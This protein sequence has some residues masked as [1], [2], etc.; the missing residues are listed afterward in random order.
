MKYFLL[1]FV[2]LFIVRCRNDDR[3]VLPVTLTRDSSITRQNAYSDLFLDSLKM[4][5]FLKA[6][7]N[8]DS[9]KTYIRSFYN[10]RNFSFAWFNEEGLTIQTEGF[11]NLFNQY[12]NNSGDSNLYYSHLNNT[13]DGLLYQDT[14]NEVNADSLATI[15]LRLTKCFFYYVKRVYGSKADPEI[16]QWHIP[17][18]KL[19]A[20]V[21]LDSFISLN[22]GEWRPLSDRFYW[23]RNAIIEYQKIQKK[24]GWQV[25][26]APPKKIKP[27]SRDSLISIL[28]NRLCIIKSYSPNDTSDLFNDTLRI[29]IKGIRKQFGLPVYNYIDAALIKELNVSVEDRLKQM[30]IN[31]ERMK[32]MPRQPLNFISVN[33]P[34]FLFRVYDSSNER[35]TMKVVVGKVANRT[36]I[37]SDELEFIVFSPYWNVPRS[38]VQNEIYPA[39]KRSSSYLRQTN[40]E[41]TGYYN[42]GLPIVRQK[43]G[44]GNALGQVKFIF[45][46]SYN[47]YFHDTPS[48]SLFDRNKRAFSHGCI[49]LENP[50]ELARYLLRNNPFWPE[51]AIR[52]AMNSNKERWVTLNEP[53]P[54]FITYFTCWADDKGTV[55]FRDDV[56]GHD[57]K[58]G[59]HL[60][61]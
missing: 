21:L 38:I 10:G 13:I 42:D 52:N 27:G 43:P 30:L 24:G 39:M 5:A 9:S 59:K 11:W 2:I 20:T 46:N 47:I 12:L 22:K 14:L 34:E 19:N 17:K 15:E 44:R 41:V 57:K 31:L 45:P 1:F 60:F 32:W 29:A 55:Y 54:V 16:M 61:E 23:L 4:E 50:T 3:K 36:V 51:T 58:L 7:V 35:L 26:D 8:S 48:K 53:L 18:R 6:E 37:F 28:K 25:I 56:Y 49:R 40:M 33:I